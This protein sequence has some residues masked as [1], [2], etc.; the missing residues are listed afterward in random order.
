MA[1]SDARRFRVV[2]LNRTQDASIC[3]LGVGGAAVAI[4][5]ERL[6]RQKHAW[7]SLGDVSSVYA[8]SI[9]DLAGGIDLVVECY[10]SDPEALR[11]DAYTDELRRAAPFTEKGQILDVSHHLAHLYSC[12]YPSSFEECAV[13]IVDCAGSPLSRVTEAF[14]NAGGASDDAVETASYYHVD[15]GNIR[16]LKK[17]VWSFDWTRPAGLGAFYHLVTRRIFPGEGSEGKVMAL[18][19]FG[20]AGRLGLPPLRVR[21][22]EITIPPAWM[23]ILTCTDDFTV[24]PASA[25]SLQRAA[26]LA[27]AAQASFETALLETARWLRRVTGSNN[28]CFA[29]GTALNCPANTVIARQAGFS[30]VYIPPAPHDGGTAIGCALYGLSQR[31]GPSACRSFSWRSDYLGVSRSTHRIESVATARSSVTVERPVDI[32]AVTAR[33]IAN[34]AIVG[35]FQDRSEFGPRALGNRSILADPR[36]PDIQRRINETVKGRE[37]FR[38]LAPTV[39]AH[40]ADEYFGWTTHSPF[41]QYAVPVRNERAHAIPGVV[42]RDRTARIQMLRRSDNPIFFDVITEFERLTGV[43]MLLNTSFNG[44]DEPIVETVEEAFT[45][46]GATEMDGL[47]CPPFLVTK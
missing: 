47:A 36:D 40:R 25:P 46:F 24:S 17:D 37:L 45:C 11:R 42:H 13:M 29:G 15:N 44:A 27:A 8:P 14:G 28:L 3:I 31:H 26:D 10:S 39:L 16:C 21:H 33:L 23:E 4:Q 32:A 35:L 22:G 7:G 38:P 12:Y 41:M 18:A 9:D 5:K 1:V 20:D 30:R 6:T 34:G 2:G 19:S 43:P